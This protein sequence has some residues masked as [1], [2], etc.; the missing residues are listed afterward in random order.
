MEHLSVALW[1]AYYKAGK[2]VS[3]SKDVQIQAGWY[4]W[5]CADR[6]LAGKTKRL[7][8]IISRIADGGKVRRYDCYVWFKNNCPLSSPLY[9]D[10]RFASMA[11]GET[12]MTVAVGAIWNDHR[13]VVYGLDPLGV[14]HWGDHSD[15][16]KDGDCL[17]ATDSVSELVE[18]FN[19]PWLMDST[20]QSM[21]V[22][23]RL[24]KEVM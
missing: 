23:A 11:T 5:F 12:Q 17:F 20:L 9:D 24:T 21:I 19:R 8:A 3:P 1:S 16:S 4:D 7:G 14:G 18:W 15:F 22:R 6:L 10:F 2:F 13:Y